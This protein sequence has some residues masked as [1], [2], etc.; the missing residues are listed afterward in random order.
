M[1]PAATGVELGTLL[2]IMGGTFGLTTAVIALL[3]RMLFKTYREKT[4]DKLDTL[5]AEYK[6]R[7]DGLAKEVADA[8]QDR[9]DCEIRGNS[10][11]SRLQS[12]ADKLQDQWLEFQ[13]SAATLE[14]TRG[15]RLDAMFNVLDHQKDEIR[16][17]RPAI[18]KKQEELQQAGMEEMR[19]YMRKLVANQINPPEVRDAGPD[20]RGR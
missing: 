2:T 8:I 10:S 11:V 4:D 18:L 17:L 6:T 16:G 14:A 5:R 3:V 12:I 9:R 20:Q 15:E 7:L 1:N 13:K 19:L